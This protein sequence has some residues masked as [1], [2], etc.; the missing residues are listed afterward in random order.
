MPKVFII[1]TVCAALLVWL[2]LGKLGFW[3]KTGEKVI[4]NT[5]EIFIEDKEVPEESDK[6]REGK[7][8][9]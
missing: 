8:D 2:I 1:L 5:K 4:K 7:E 3:E 6:E 9:E